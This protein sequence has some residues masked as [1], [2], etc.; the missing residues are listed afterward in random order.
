[1]GNA[2]AATSKTFTTLA[3]TADTTA[4]TVLMTSP[5]HD[6]S[7]NLGSMTKVSLWFSEDITAVSGTVTIKLGGTSLTMGVTSSNVTVSGSQ[8]DLAIF[9]GRLNS[10]GIWNV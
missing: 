3:G 1:M 2:V 4:P 7:G 8:M 9:P 5:A 6:S 10:A